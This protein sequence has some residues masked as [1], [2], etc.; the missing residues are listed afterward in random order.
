MGTRKELTRV[1]LGDLVR[2]LEAQGGW[3]FRIEIDGFWGSF[4]EVDGALRATA[5]LLHANPEARAGLQVGGVTLTEDGD[6]LGHTLSVARRLQSRSP[7]GN[8]LIGSDVLPRSREPLYFA[9]FSEPFSLEAKGLG[10]IEAVRM[11]PQ[12]VS[13]GRAFKF[14]D[15]YRPEDAELFFGRER[16]LEQLLTVLERNGWAVLF[17]PSGVGKSSLLGICRVSTV[18]QSLLPACGSRFPSCERQLLRGQSLWKLVG[19]ETTLGGRMGESGS[20]LWRAEIPLG[21]R[22]Q[23]RGC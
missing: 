20:R 18:S 1:W 7:W 23:P 21:E 8:A 22:V 19:K 9:H 10:R 6:L 13:R 4:P 11:E 17:G 5:E 12:I 15:A 16:E 14:L 3:L 2:A